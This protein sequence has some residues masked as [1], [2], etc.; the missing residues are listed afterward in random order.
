[1]FIFLFVLANCAVQYYIIGQNR[2]YGYPHLT[3]IPPKLN[4]IRV[5]KGHADHIQGMHADLIQS[6]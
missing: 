5:N 3:E 6:Q 4:F 1:M 2:S